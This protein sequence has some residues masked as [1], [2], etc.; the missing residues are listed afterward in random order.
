MPQS[1]KRTQPASAPLASGRMNKREATV[2]AENAVQCQSVVWD[3]DVDGGA[4]G[5]IEFGVKLP[6]NSIIYKILTDEQTAVVGA[7]DIVLNAGSTALSA[8]MDMTAD[9][10]V[11]DRGLD[12]AAD[13][14]KISAAEEL[15][16]DIATNPATAGKVRFLVFFVQ[17][18]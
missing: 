4:V 17:S 7:N 11:Q 3:F 18:K 8:T 12:G 15:N 10:G 6:A 14:V 1:P 5:N 16:M 13:G 2:I 9:A